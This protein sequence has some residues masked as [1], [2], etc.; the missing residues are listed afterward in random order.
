MKPGNILIH[1]SN[2]LLTDF[3][4]WYVAVFVYVLLV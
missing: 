1:G 4:F 2:I 3:G